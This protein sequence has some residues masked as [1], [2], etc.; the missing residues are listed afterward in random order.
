MQQMIGVNALIILVQLLLLLR[1]QY[2]FAAVTG[3]IVIGYNVNLLMEISK[4][5]H[6]QGGLNQGNQDQTAVSEKGLNMNILTL[7]TLLEILAFW[8]YVGVKVLA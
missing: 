3:W 7:I 1:A 4:S 8:V 5:M 2:L 6:E